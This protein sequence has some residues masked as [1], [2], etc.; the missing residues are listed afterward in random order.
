MSVLLWLRNLSHP[1]GKVSVHQ[2]PTSTRPL[3]LTHPGSTLLKELLGF[4]VV[5]L[6][7]MELKLLTLTVWNKFH[8]FR[9]FLV[10]ILEDYL[11][12]T[13]EEGIPLGTWPGREGRATFFGSLVGWAP[14][15]HRPGHEDGLSKHVLDKL[16]L[17]PTATWL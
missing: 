7:G 12:H 1:H 15:D 2:R 11:S 5:I 6:H 16:W 8:Q 14:G 10:G 9:E 17:F 3:S 4:F 13:Q